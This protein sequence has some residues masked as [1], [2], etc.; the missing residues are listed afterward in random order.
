[1]FGLQSQADT[2]DIS[3]QLVSL[4]S[5]MSAQYVATSKI[6]FGDEGDYGKA[7]A[8]VL[9]VVSN[10]MLLAVHA[11]LVAVPLWKKVSAAG[12]KLQEH[13][14]AGANCVSVIFDGNCHCLSYQDD[15]NIDR[16]ITANL[17]ASISVLMFLELSPV[18]IITQD[19]Q[20]L[21]L[22]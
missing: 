21:H 17:H 15:L 9:F 18:R 3:T 6:P 5:I 20:C 10:T 4:M 12:L 2:L 7:G 13:F 1:M 22:V 14:A 19:C 11:V 16:T 8:T